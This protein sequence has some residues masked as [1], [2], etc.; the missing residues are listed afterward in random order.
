MG[1]V[2]VHQGP[3]K[4]RNDL[5]ADA[6]EEL[7]SVHLPDHHGPVRIAPKDVSLVAAPV[8]T[9]VQALLTT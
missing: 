3:Q 1:T 7:T 4:G 8:P 2:L 6:R 5:T 9:M